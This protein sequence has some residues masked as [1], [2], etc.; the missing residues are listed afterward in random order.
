[1][2]RLIALTPALADAVRE[3]RQFTAITG[4]HVADV[5]DQVQVIAR[6]D[7]AHRARVGWIP[8]WAGFLAVD[9]AR[10]QVVGVGAY[11]AAP[12]SDGAVEI[13]YGTFTPYEGQGYATQIAGALIARASDSDAV[14]LVYAHTLPN[15]NASTRILEKHGFVPA[16]MAHDDDAGAVRRWELRL[17]P[18]AD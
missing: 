7:A 5:A 15:P 13:A 18:R 12:D 2:L 10:Q 14:R 16:G 9:D 4:A 8:E 1:M 11:V 17:R 6:Q 3:P